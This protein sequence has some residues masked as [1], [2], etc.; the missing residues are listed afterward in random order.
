MP[1]KIIFSVTL[2]TREGRGARVR[3]LRGDNKNSAKTAITRLRSICQYLQAI[4][5]S[6]GGLPCGK[7]V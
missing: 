2:A 5:G 7:R 3:K 6:L 1:A 4:A